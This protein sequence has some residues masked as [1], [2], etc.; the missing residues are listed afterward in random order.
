MHGRIHGCSTTTTTEGTRPLVAAIA[1]ISEL[2]IVRDSKGAFLRI[3]GVTASA[4]SGSAGGGARE[5]EGGCG[6][7]GCAIS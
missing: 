7:A 1:D 6:G 4:S 3:E 2:P 5:A